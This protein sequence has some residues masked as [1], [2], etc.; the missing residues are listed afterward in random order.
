LRSKPSC[1]DWG[2]VDIIAISSTSDLQSC[3]A[4]KRPEQVEYELVDRSTNPIGMTGART[5]AKNVSWMWITNRSEG[6]RR[7]QARS[8][9][10][11]EKAA[12]SGKMMMRSGSAGARGERVSIG[13]QIER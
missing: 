5:Y 13:M 10:R 1:R 6:V 3:G 12:D 2:A 7:N 11:D 8:E 9:K 4:V